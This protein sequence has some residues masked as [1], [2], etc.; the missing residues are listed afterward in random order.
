[1]VLKGNQGNLRDYVEDCFTS[2][3]DNDYLTVPH[4]Y[5]E[6]IDGDHG[7][8]EI[9]LQ[10]TIEE[11]GDFPG[12]AAWKDLNM[13][14]MIESERHIGDL[15]SLLTRNNV[16]QQISTLTEWGL[17]MVP[18]LYDHVGSADFDKV[19]LAIELGMRE[20][21]AHRVHQADLGL[22]SK[23]TQTIS[24]RADFGFASGRIALH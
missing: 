21:K 9:R 8:V 23:T 17:L 1:M 11:H 19:A 13:I 5:Y 12:K 4:G 3:M 18:S 10:W 24:G 20:G 2:A 16:E 6:T 22:C 15:S 14:G 7:R